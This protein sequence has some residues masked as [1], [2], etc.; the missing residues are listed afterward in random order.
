MFYERIRL[1]RKEKQWTQQQAADRLHISRSTYS[2]YENG[3][4]AITAT[5]LVELAYIYHTSVDYLLDCTNNPSPYPP[6]KI[7]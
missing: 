3:K 2:K 4:N 7:K 1:L 5:M 6:R